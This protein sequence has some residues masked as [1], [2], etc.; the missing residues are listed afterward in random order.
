MRDLTKEMSG[1]KPLWIP[2]QD[3]HKKTALFAETQ[4]VTWPPWSLVCFLKEFVTTLEA[5]TVLSI[6]KQLVDLVFCDLLHS[7]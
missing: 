4:W 5:M 3:K 6:K 1:P 7:G 2:A